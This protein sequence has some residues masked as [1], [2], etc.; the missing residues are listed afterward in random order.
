MRVVVGRIGRAQGI[1]GEV[2]V[3][4]R[5]DEPETH[6]APGSV[7]WT[8]PGVVGPLTVA[9]LRWQGPRLVVHFAGVGDRNGAEA[10]RGVLLEAERAESAR[11]ADPDEFYD[12]QLVGLAAVDPTGAPLGVVTEVVH[13]PAQD[14]L[15]VRTPDDREVLVPFV[16]ALVP[17]VDLEAGRVVVDP[18]GGLFDEAAAETAGGPGGV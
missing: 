9:S 14:L 17:A 13:L 6:F 12:H 8:D 10:L 2:N 15:A 1:R 4:P 7:L 11:P 3:E 5:T 18:P 16:T